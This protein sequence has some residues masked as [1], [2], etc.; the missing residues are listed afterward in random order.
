[1]KIGWRQLPCDL[2]YKICNL[3]PSI[4]E[5]QSELMEDIQFYKIYKAYK[6]VQREHVYA[7]LS[8]GI[9][10]AWLSIESVFTMNTYMPYKETVLLVLELMTNEERDNFEFPQI[11][12]VFIDD[13][14]SVYV[15]FLNV[16]IQ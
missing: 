4:Q 14:R 15:K 8:W 13:T 2:V 1:M 12:S 7:Q 11:D 16:Y 6:I 5:D 3:L 9:L 10:W